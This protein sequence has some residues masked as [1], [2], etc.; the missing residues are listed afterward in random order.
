MSN[1]SIRKGQFTN[2]KTIRQTLPTSHE[3]SIG[4][5]V[6][7]EATNLKTKRPTKKMDDKQVGPFKIL[8]K[9]GAVAYKL[10][11]PSTWHHHPIFNKLLLMPYTAP[12]FPSQTIPRP[13]PELNEEGVPLYE[14]EKILSSR[15]VGRGTQ[16]L[17]KWK[18]YPE[19]ENT[20]EPERNLT[21]ALDVL[22]DFKRSF[23]G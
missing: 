15:K 5:K 16:Y 8:K 19:S 23:Q 21:Q 3:Y 20:W 14:V 6:W 10:K 17:I 4:D 2:E 11:L 12:T 7:L 13:P 9:V 1:T 18:G 22:A